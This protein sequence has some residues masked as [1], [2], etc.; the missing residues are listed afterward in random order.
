M[1][2][3]VSDFVDGPIDIKRVLAA[4]TEHYQG[5][6]ESM[7]A[8]AIADRLWQLK[9]ISAKQHQL[10]FAFPTHVHKAEY[11]VQL[12]NSG[13]DYVTALTTALVKTGQDYIARQ[14]CLI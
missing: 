12:I 7:N 6:V 11:I 10:L 8:E 1:I 13:P 3:C 5:V 9:A 14:L 4:R 2:I